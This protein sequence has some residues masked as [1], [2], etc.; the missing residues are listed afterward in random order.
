MANSTFDAFFNDPSS[1]HYIPDYVSEI[2]A[3]VSEG[4]YTEARERLHQLDNDGSG[5]N[6]NAIRRAVGINT[7]IYL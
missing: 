5:T 1:P 4:K 3:L 7:G 6:T 2:Q